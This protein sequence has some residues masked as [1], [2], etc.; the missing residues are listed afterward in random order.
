MIGTRTCTG[1]LLRGQNLA[2]ELRVPLVASDRWDRVNRELFERF[3]VLNLKTAERTIEEVQ[4]ALEFSGGK[5]VFFVTSPDH[6]PRVVRDVLSCGG[7]NSI[8]GSSDS[9]FSTQGVA[10]V[11]GREPG[12]SKLDAIQSTGDGSA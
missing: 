4:S 9:A 3:K 5:P 7:L 6:L 8:F 12:H 2:D 11:K 1:R 10:D